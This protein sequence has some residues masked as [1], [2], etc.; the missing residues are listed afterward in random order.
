LFRGMTP[1]PGAW[2]RHRDKTVKVIECRPVPSLQVEAGTV[3]AVRPE[4]FVGLREGG[5]CLRKVQP[6]GRAVMD[7]ASFAN[8]AR[9][10]PGDRLMSED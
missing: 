5:L 6:E 1:A 3:G 10:S 4:L 9:L 2:F 8:G 7:A